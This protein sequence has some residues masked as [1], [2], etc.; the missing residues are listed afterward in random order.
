MTQRTY[1][2]LRTFLFWTGIMMI[3]AMKGWCDHDG[4]PG[5]QGLVS[6]D[7]GY[8]I[9][10]VRTGQRNGQTVIFAA[11]YEG[12]LFCFNFA[13]HCE[14]N[15]VLSG[16]MVHDLWPHDLD[17]DGS[18]ELLVA[19]ADGYL[20]CLD[21]KN[22]EIQWTFS[23]A[24]SVHKTPMYAVC[25]VRD[26]AGNVFIA[27]G[28]FDKNLYYLNTKGQ[29]L[30]TV[31]SSLYSRDI[32]WGNAKAV[33]YGHAVNFLRPVSQ[34]DG[35]EHLALVSMMNHMQSPGSL[36]LFKPLADIPYLK[37]GIPGIK[38]C[39][40][41]TLCD[42][43]GDGTDEIIFGGSGLT[44]D[45]ATF[46]DPVTGEKRNIRLRDNGPNGYRVTMV[47]PIGR[48]IQQQYL[49]LCGKVINLLPLNL[50]TTKVEKVV[51]KYAFYDLWKEPSSGKVILAS[52]QSGG[53]CIHILDPSVP[54]WKQAFQDL[55][56]PGKIRKIKKNLEHLHRLVEQYQ[57]PAWERKPDPVY[58][59][60]SDHPL[61]EKIRKHYAS[62]VFFHAYWGRGHVENTKWRYRK[63]T[64]VVP[65]K[66][67]EGRDRRCHYDLEQDEVVKQICREFE[68]YDAVEFWAGHGNDPLYYS[69]ETILKIL[70]SNRNR[71]TFL[72]WPEL[73]H[74]GK[75][76]QWVV[77]HIFYRLAKESPEHNAWLV[78]K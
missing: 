74:D 17:R 39:N 48:G 42:T 68:L 71:K 65:R 20:Y 16:F 69:P 6:F 28:N 53:S 9:T 21:G 41:L 12:I 34:P 23:P 8:T 67:R 72:V 57:P 11:S 59:P 52:V 54:G 5:K 73:P 31:R 22:G 45:P 62:P 50:D 35:G 29:K 27:C 32:P 38:T 70:K 63:E 46:F 76:F 15:R 61:V 58:V 56:P 44:Y 33:G 36:Y 64:Y 66:Y 1:T 55:E 37:T 4:Q 51:G 43:N 7:T 49:V 60:V 10:K 24:R 19:C 40:T 75:D 2:R 26:R 47:T 78:F 14:W 30:K 77:D 13:G 3:F 25:T 18:D